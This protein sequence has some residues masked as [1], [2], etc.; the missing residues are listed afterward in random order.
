[1][2]FALVVAQLRGGAEALG[3]RV[4]ATSDAAALQRRA[5]QGDVL[6]LLGKASGGGFGAGCEGAAGRVLLEAVR[7]KR[8]VAVFYETECYLEPQPRASYLLAGKQPFAEVWTYSHE[9]L[10]LLAAPPS[11]RSP[12]PPSDDVLRGSGVAPGTRTVLLP[13]GYSRG[14]DFRSSPDLGPPDYGRAVA[15]VA[16]GPERRLGALWAALG[17]NASVL[18]NVR[19]AWD[20]AGWATLVA[21]HH[22]AVDV[23]KPEGFM[24]A[25]FFRL[26]PL[27]SS[28]LRVVSAR[29]NA[30][31]EASL[32]GLVDFGATD[33]MAVKVL[34][35]LE[36]ARNST[37]RRAAQER[38]AA[39][40][41]ERFNVTRMLGAEL[42]RLGF[43]VYG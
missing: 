12:A 9:T 35:F 27:L 43:V 38:T 8:L 32:R 37:A 7:S 2:C 21:N 19:E 39:A 6:L 30:D 16:A 14:V 1:M 29:S 23:H 26:S 36:E 11:P 20:D 3:V 5:G 31:D 42:Q 33:V 25:N 24:D 17:A 41:A 34:A 40:Y 13:P 10:R 22:V 15:T 18:V 4:A 28:G